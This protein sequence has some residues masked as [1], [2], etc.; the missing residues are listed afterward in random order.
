MPETKK[1]KLDTILARFGEVGQI[2]AVGIVSKEGLLITALMPPEMNERIVA[3]LCST[4]MASAETASTQ[5]GTGEVSDIHV[6]TDEGTILLQPA[7]EKAILIALA[8]SGAQLGLIMMEIEA[9]AKQVQ[10]ILEE[11]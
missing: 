6:K 5:M 8:D 11:V 3:A 2:K 1:D 9:R 7:G 4:I 10:E